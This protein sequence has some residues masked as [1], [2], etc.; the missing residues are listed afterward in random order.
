MKL[1]HYQQI[2]NKLTINVR[3]FI[4]DLRKRL[5]FIGIPLTFAW[6][7]FCALKFMVWKNF[8]ELRIRLKYSTDKLDFNKI[9]WIDPQKIEYYLDRRFN[10]WHNYSR[11]LKGD[12]DRPKKKFADLDVYQAFQQRF[13]EG[14]KWT[15][16]EF[17]HRVLNE[18]S[19]GVRKWGCKNKQEW[20][21]RLQQI[22]SL[23]HKIKKHGYKSRKDIHSSKGLIGKIE[24]PATILDDVSVI[25]DRDGQLLFIDGRHRLSIAKILNLPKIPFRI[26]ARHK[27]WMDF[28]KELIFFAEN[29]QSGELYQL[30]THPDLQDIPFKH[31][32]DRFELIK[33]NLSVSKGTL[34]DIGANLG[35]FCHKFEDEGFDCHA[36]EENRKCVYFLNKLKKAENRKFKIIPKSVFEYN[37]KEDIVF[38]VVLALNIF[39]HFLEKKD[40][41]LGLIQ[42]LKRL[43]IKELIFEPHK[44]NE[45]GNRNLY[46][47]YSPDEFVNF[48]IKN[49]C[50]D[51][52]QFIGNAKDGRSLYKLTSKRSL[53]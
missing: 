44:L 21:E 1:S 27:K 20:N 50:L 9:C 36:L 28:R 23:Y 52:A 17:Y 29:Y 3:S 51:K 40:T 33:N 45:W 15:E 8:L 11:V 25:I 4:F 22:E 35:Y 19:Q 26:I 18:I 10:P 13:H 14:K 16:T 47:D 2:R 43:K 49:S 37:K 30:L 6:R 7:V 39:H 5:P 38:D 31:G 42:F 34:L 32:G 46:K 12:S 41:Y 24:K 48:I 53:S